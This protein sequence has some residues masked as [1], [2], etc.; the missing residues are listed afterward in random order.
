[1]S[2]KVPYH[3][4]TATQMDS[5]RS[6]LVIKLEPKN[7]R[8]GRVTNITVCEQKE[9]NVYIP[10]HIA[11]SMGFKPTSHRRYEKLHFQGTLKPKQEQVKK[12]AI[13]H[14][15]K[16]GV[17][18]LSMHTGFG[19]TITTLALAATSIRMRACVVVKGLVLCKQWIKS[20][21]TFLPDAQ[22]KL[23]DSKTE[24]SDDYNFLIVNA[25]NIPKMS[26]LN[27]IGLVIV[28]ECHQIVSQV[29]SQG[30]L[31]FQPRFL[32][33]LSATPYRMDGLDKLIQLYF[34]T[35]PIVRKMQ[36]PHQVYRLDTTF[37]PELE[38]SQDG[39][40]IW[41]S[42]L[43][44]QGTCPERN[45]FIIRLTQYFQTKH[46]LILTKRVEQ[47]KYL[48][49]KLVAMGEPVCA[50]C[51][52]TSEVDDNVRIIVGIAAKAGTGFDH[53]SLD[54][55]ILASDVEA[56]FI[57]YLGRVFRRDDVEPVII[58]IVDKHKSLQRHFSTRKKAYI[59]AGGTIEKIK[60]DH[61]WTI[62]RLLY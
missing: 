50:L 30:L 1:M 33:G 25:I 57:Q 34:G 24:Y 27:K 23:F 62:P 9:D 3:Q 7:K 37:E 46:I 19:K 58:D 15:N 49:E 42:M 54:M 38:Y 55:M 47:V 31:H 8:Y 41:N 52:D 17:A 18:L 35:S 2:I 43:N 48:I 59:E 36:R 12:E 56:Y 60:I 51:E 16:D 26:W 22:V 32:I 11:K 20:I 10:Y 4:L 6:K 21:Q 61:E 45:D 40:V 5:L 44:S 14:L 53:A 39:T 13:S 28:D 29:L